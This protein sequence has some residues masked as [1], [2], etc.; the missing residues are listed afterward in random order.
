MKNLTHHHT[1]L[2]QPSIP[3]VTEM[4]QLRPRTIG[5]HLTATW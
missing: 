5:A 4:Y 2:Q 3:S 1:I